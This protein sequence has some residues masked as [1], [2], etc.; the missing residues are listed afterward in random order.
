MYKALVETGGLIAQNDFAKIGQIF[1]L[2]TIIAIVVLVV[3]K[4][5]KKK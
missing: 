5:V 2:I 3:L 1:G 4:I